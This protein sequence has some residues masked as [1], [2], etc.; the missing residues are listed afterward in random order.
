MSK[1]LE[2]ILGGYATDTLTEEESRQLMEAALHDQALFDALADEE[3]LKALLADQ[4]TRQRILA[5]LEESQKS[6]WV[7]PSYRSWFSWFRQPSSLAWAGSIA[8]MGLAL[9]FGWQLE[10]DWGPFVEQDEQAQRPQAKDHET[11]DMTSRPQASQVATIQEK[12]EDRHQ[13]GQPEAEPV[14]GVSSP[15]PSR[16]SSSTAKVSKNS[17]SGRQLS[18][19]VPSE[20]LLREEITKERRSKAR[21]LA[22]HDPAAAIVQ[23]VPKAE[24]HVVQS[25]TSPASEEQ[26]LQD[27]AQMPSY[28][29]K[30]EGVDAISS[31]Q[32][33]ELVSA[34]ERARADVVDENLD[35]E[36]TQQGLGAM[37]PQAPKTL[38]AEVAAVKKNQDVVQAYSQGQTKGIRYRFI[39]PVVD[40][41]DK[42]VDVSEFSGKWSKLHVVIES[43]V[44][45]HLYALTT[46][47]KG[48]WQWM[49]PRSPQVKVLTDGAI[50]MKGF[51]SVNYA[52]SQVT[53]TLGKPVVSSITVLLASTP[54]ADLGK[55]LGRG[56]S[57]QPFEE[58]LI[59]PRGT[60]TFVINP[61]L[62]SGVPLKVDILLEVEKHSNKVLEPLPPN[63]SFQ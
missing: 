33:T 18:A 45:G 2:Q 15:V 10:K 26:D 63:E 28:A 23:Q 7:A 35:G 27:L 24:Q 42:A 49:R 4:K 36:R 32:A 43:N 3:A 61:L 37:V 51:R 40:G 20:D 46:F 19:Q 54:I 48:K 30:R 60:D 17:A 1:S 62:E 31:P 38:S 56:L 11:N 55:W 25:V 13:K 50:K 47:G 14:E 29:A 22:S 58:N 16:S 6:L 21:E 5:S 12:L 57:R 53:N 52:I 59:E 44:S 34:K 39:Q 41:K 8:A 9:I